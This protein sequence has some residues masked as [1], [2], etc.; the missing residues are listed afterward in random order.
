CELTWDEAL[1]GTMEVATN[2]SPEGV[3]FDDGSGCSNL[4]FSF[5]GDYAIGFATLD[6]NSLVVRTGSPVFTG[7]EL[8]L[9]GVSQLKALGIGSG[10]EFILEGGTVN[11]ARIVVGDIP[12]GDGE[13]ALRVHNDGTVLA[14]REAFPSSTPLDLI[15]GSQ[16]DAVVEISD[17]A[18]VSAARVRVGTGSLIDGRVD[19]DGV[20]GSNPALL[21]ASTGVRIGDGGNGVVM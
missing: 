2:W 16:Q 21:V 5:P 10:G 20:T 4:I 6:T 17:G 7:T 3:P 15:I 1:G 19:I 8:S 14:S 9:A 18:A 12:G 13:S 11:A